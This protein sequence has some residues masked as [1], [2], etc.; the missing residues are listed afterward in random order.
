VIDAAV[1]GSN[2]LTARWSAAAADGGSTALSGAAV[3]PLLAYLGAAAAGKARDELEAALG[4]DAR[5]AAASATE[6]IGEL[7]R[8]PA[9][10]TA[11]GVWTRAEVELSAWARRAVPAHARGSLA[12]DVAESQARIDTWVREQTGGL[13]DALPASISAETL[14]L[15]A[16]ALTVRTSWETPFEPFML[17]PDTGPW[18]NE[19]LVGLSR[20]TPDRDD[21]EV[22]STSA[23]ELTVVTL[24]AS[25]DVVVELVL[26]REDRRPHEVLHAAVEYANGGRPAR[27]GSTLT[28]QDRAP[29]VTVGTWSFAEGPELCVLVPRFR[30]DATHDL[31]AHADVFGLEAATDRDRGHFPRLSDSPLAVGDARQGITASF[32]EL[33]FEAAAVTSIELRA[34]GVPPRRPQS[35]LVGFDRPFAFVARLRSSGLVLLAG[36]VGKAERFPFDADALVER[37]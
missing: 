27:P 1:E 23:G 36:W 35:I 12:G 21:L 22:V 14:L 31:L 32:A 6:L 30:V 20:S 28:E 34:G 10:R 7:E 19:R 24:E 3:W 13:I 18:R 2:A 5:D 9:V 29:G 4:V 8:S 17:I 15:L 25:H 26:G 11:V 33:G 16:A 37:G